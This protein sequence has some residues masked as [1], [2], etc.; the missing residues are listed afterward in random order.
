MA[1]SMVTRAHLS[2]LIAALV[3]LLF[4]SQSTCIH[5]MFHAVSKWASGYPSGSIPGWLV[6]G[7]ASW[8]GDKVNRDLDLSTESN[9]YWRRVTSYFGGSYK[10]GLLG[11]SYRASPFWTYFTEQSG[12]AT[13]PEPEFGLDKM[14]EYWYGG[15]VDLTSVDLLARVEDLLPAA[16]TRSFETFVADWGTANYVHDLGNL[17]DVFRYI[18]AEEM[19]PGGYPAL[20]DL[21]LDE[22]LTVSDSFAGTFVVNAWSHQYLKL[23]PIAS[24]IRFV[25][26]DVRQVC[27]RLC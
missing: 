1:F 15:G 13:I 6:E 25:N 16:D 26:I 24:L 22:A 14:S 9:T 12:S 5:E 7:P 11:L 8:S 3:V 18:D 20:A 2:N 17:P 23:S 19:T 4:C 27:A 21:A 10:T